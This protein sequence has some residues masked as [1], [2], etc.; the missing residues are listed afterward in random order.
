LVVIRLDNILT[1][2]NLIECRFRGFIDAPLL[3][4]S[5]TDKVSGINALK[6]TSARGE[7]RYKEIRFGWRYDGDFLD[8]SHGIGIGANL[9]AAFII[10]HQAISTMFAHLI[11][12]HSSS[13]SLLAEF[14]AQKAAGSGYFNMEGKI[15]L[16][17]WGAYIA[18]SG[19]G[20]LYVDSPEGWGGAYFN[21]S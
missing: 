14:F 16:Q 9:L 1:W 11:V 13:Q 8:Y 3:K 19:T 18:V 2:I 15:L 4:N 17:E 12:R 6:I 20:A 10:R 7:G 5:L 21:R